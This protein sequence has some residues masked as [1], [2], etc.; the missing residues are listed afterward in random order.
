MKFAFI[1]SVIPACGCQHTINTSPKMKYPE[2]FI[3]PDRHT[4]VAEDTKHNC[5]GYVPFANEFSYF[6]DYTGQGY[7][8]IDDEWRCDVNYTLADIITGHAMR[9]AC[10]FP[11]REELNRL[12]NIAGFPSPQTFTVAQMSE[13]EMKE[14]IMHTLCVL[15]QPVILPVKSRFFGSVVIGYKDNGNT[16][17]TYGYPPLFMDW[18]NTQPRIEEVTDWYHADTELTIVGKRERTPSAKEMYEAGLAQILAYFEAGLRG[19]DRRHYDEWERFLRLGMDEM[20]AEVKRT[21]FVPGAHANDA[22]FSGEATDENIKKHLQSIADP[23]W[24]EM[25]ERRYYIMHFFRQAARHFPEMKDEMKKIEDHFAWSNTIM[26]SEYVKETG[27][28]EKWNAGAFENPEVRARMADCV[29]RFREADGKGLQMVEKLLARMGMHRDTFETENLVIRRWRKTDAEDLRRYAVYK[30]GTGFETWE[31]W[32]TE[33]V[34]CE[35]CAA[36]FATQNNGWAVERKSDSRVI[37]FVSFNEVK[38]RLLDFGHAFTHPLVEDIALKTEALA[39][40]VQY[41]FYV[42]D[43]DAVDT[44]NEK[45][46]TDNTAPLF[47]LGFAEL[48]DKMQITREKWIERNKKY[49]AE[50][51]IKPKEKIAAFS[52]NKWPFSNVEPAVYAALGL[53]YGRTEK[54]DDNGALVNSDAEYSLHNVL[55]GHAFGLF[56]CWEDHPLSMAAYGF[57]SRRAEHKGLTADEITAFIKHEIIRGNAVHINEGNGKYDYLIWGFRDNGKVLLGH[58]FEHGNDGLNCAYDFDN[59]VEFE[60]LT[61]I[62]NDET[63]F[64]RNGETIAGIIIISPD[65]EKQDIDSLFRRALAEG[66]RMFTQTEAPPFM[67]AP[68]MHFTYGQAM[69]DEWIRLLEQANAENSE[70]FYFASPVFPHFIALHENRLHLFKTLGEHAKT[71][72]DEHLAKAVAL[73]GELK[74]IAIEGAQIGYENKYSKP[75]VLAMTNNGRRE[76]LIGIL[77]KCRALELEIA[78]ELGVF[79]DGLEPAETLVKPLNDDF[80]L[81]E[82]REKHVVGVRVACPPLA[83]LDS[84]DI[85]RR[86]ILEGTCELLEKQVG[87]KNPGQYVAVMCDVRTG[88]DFT[89]VIGVEVAAGTVLPEAL[90]PGAVAFTIPAATFAKRVKRGDESANNALSSFSYSDF[91]RD[92][93]YAWSDAS[94]PFSYYDRDG[95]ML[96]TYQ[97]V[98]Q[99]QTEAEKYDSVSYEIVT[100]P[101]VKIIAKPGDNCMFDFFK[102]MDKAKKVPASRLHWGTFAAFGGKNT[103]GKQAAYFGVRVT[104][105]EDTPEGFEEA[106]Y[107][108]R[109]FVRM[110]QRQT[111]N[112]N[113]S[114]LFD[115]GKDWFFKNHP[116]YEA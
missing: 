53:L 26:G 107:P 51:V 10:L 102:E 98:K 112:D 7:G 83:R 116:E 72:G 103:D 57:N 105:F 56:Y 6:L 95:E 50:F 110:F 101:D 80:S 79:L 71:H 99:P 84:V 68:R 104:H 74:D 24:C 94:F 76:L 69:Y 33:I 40:M 3:L 36:Y 46:W 20:I 66:V 19:D 4:P 18:D 60:N 31:Q 32:P 49:P 90:P 97:P 54:R 87:N 28:G 25:A 55:T 63:I 29:R 52:G 48:E 92:L 109:L 1:I 108:S 43:I 88:V 14:A 30:N 91:R 39:I 96:W 22:K 70:A 59:P 58:K 44:R 111:N 114:I 67:D 45:A 62:F 81:V 35:K 2:S 8:F 73:C 61:E 75:E 9:P 17:V 41:A 11:T 100:L 64:K 78:K 93:N 16:L 5:P 89:Y 113:A 86:A 85:V 47:A 27:E 12:Y 65:G 38:D 42:L 23:V 77:R 21:R 115:G 106:V 82:T 37:G 34:E 15:G 13:A